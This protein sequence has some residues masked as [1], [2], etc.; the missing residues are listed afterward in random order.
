MYLTVTMCRVEGEDWET[1]MTGYFK[2]TR[3]RHK[4]HEIFSGVVCYTDIC[5][6]LELLSSFYDYEPRKSYSIL[7]KV[8]TD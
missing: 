1:L 4:R 2:N 5:T 6:F 7:L 3:N 8:N